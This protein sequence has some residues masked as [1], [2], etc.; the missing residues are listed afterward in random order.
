MVPSLETFISLGFLVTIL[1]GKIL[2]A[3]LPPSVSMIATVTGMLLSLD[4]KNKQRD[5][6]LTVAK[7]KVSQEE[8]KA[9]AKV[10]ADKEKRE[11]FRKGQELYINYLKATKPDGKS[12]KTLTKDARKNLK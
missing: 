6:D 2:S 3:G 11:D 7:E 8:K 10:A 4:L 12:L 1:K 5:A 9:A